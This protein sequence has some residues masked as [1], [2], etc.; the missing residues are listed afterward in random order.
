MKYPHPR[1]IN[2]SRL[3]VNRHARRIVTS[4]VTGA[5]ALSPLASGAAQAA[6]YEDHWISAAEYHGNYPPLSLELPANDTEYLDATIGL[7][8]GVYNYDSALAPSHFSQAIEYDELPAPVEY[9]TA[10]GSSSDGR[11]DSAHGEFFIFGPWTIANTSS[12]SPEVGDTLLVITEGWELP[13]R[14]RVEF[15][16]QVS[17]SVDEPTQHGGSGATRIVQPGEEGCFIWVS[18]RVYNSQSHAVYTFG[19]FG[20]TVFDPNNPDFEEPDTPSF[21]SNVRL[22]FAG[23]VSSL[24]PGAIVTAVVEGAYPTPDRIEFNWLHFAQGSGNQL[25]HWSYSNQIELDYGLLIPGTVLR[26]EA[27]SWLDNTRTLIGGAEIL[28]P[29]V[30]DELQTFENVQIILHSATQ[31]TPGQPA[32]PVGVPTAG[33]HALVS[34]TSDTLPHNATLQYRIGDGPLVDVEG[35]FFGALPWGSG[36]A[37]LPTDSAGEL[38]TVYLT[39]SRP[40]FETTTVSAYAVIAPMPVINLEVTGIP[41]IGRVLIAEAHSEDYSNFH[42]SWFLVEAETDHWNPLPWIGSGAALQ[43]RPEHAGQT[44]RVHATASRTSPEGFWLSGTAYAYVEVAM[45]DNYVTFTGATPLALTGTP[46]PGGSLELPVGLWDMFDD[47]M[48][49]ARIVWQTAEQNLQIDGYWFSGISDPR[50]F[51][52]PEH[53]TGQEVWAEITFYGRGV[54]PITIVSERLTIPAPLTV[55]D[56]V[57]EVYE[58]IAEIPNAEYLGELLET[59]LSAPETATPETIEEVVNVVNTV[60]DARNALDTLLSELVQDDLDDEQQYALDLVREALQLIQDHIRE[61]ISQTEHASIA[62]NVDVIPFYVAL[63]TEQIERTAENPVYVAIVAALE[64]ALEAFA[65][66]VAAPEEGYASV[67]TVAYGPW[68]FVTTSLA[69]NSVWTPE[70]ADEAP[71]LQVTLPP[72]FA[73]ESTDGL[74]VAVYVNGEIIPVELQPIFRAIPSPSRLARSVIV[75]DGYEIVGW[76]F[77]APHFTR[78]AIVQVTSVSILPEI[79]DEIVVEDEIVDDDQSG[80]DDE[81]LIEVGYDEEYI[82]DDASDDPV[83]NLPVPTV[84]APPVPAPAVPAAPA[85]PSGP[86]AP[87]AP[88]APRPTAPV[89]TA[90]V[91]AEDSADSEDMYLVAEAEAAYDIADYDADAEAP[92]EYVGPGYPVDADEAVAIAAG[93]NPWLV[94]TPVAI[95]G[96]LAAAVVMLRRRIAA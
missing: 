33:S 73:P 85:A 20:V 79:D 70:T 16:W 48:A 92:A 71:M 22:E 93:L 78:F 68:D 84:P 15:T 90:P 34:A 38:L 86:A 72:S 96:A 1:E 82:G 19:T 37:P 3:F 23:D 4:L 5:L 63:R 51:T 25:S 39:L 57:D 56:I 18:G 88:V 53:V 26:V 69:T 44:V 60:L 58:I 52:V 47:E 36:V 8:A 80:N 95:L 59:V 43:L 12:S 67:I 13:T 30:T 55:E 54:W 24:T 29:L 42:F 65:D 17:C 74:A 75:P 41:E 14:Y 77:E 28:I 62:S 6:E 10:P 9:P 64:D 40:G 45:P 87:S 83:A 2:F 66:A 21:P 7:D 61:A 11:E 31:Y 27:W 76:Y 32:T 89:V 46:R 49:E 50:Q 35:R 94:L 91:I 81:L